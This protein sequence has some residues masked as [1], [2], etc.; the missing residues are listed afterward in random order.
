MKKILLL[1]LLGNFGFAQSILFK[2]LSTQASK[3]TQS[4]LK[5]FEMFQFDPAKLVATIDGIPGN[6][7]ELTIRTPEQAWTVELFEYD[8]LS[9]NYKRLA[10]GIT[11]ARELPK[12]SDFRTFKGNIKGKNSIVSL[13]VADGFMKLMI[14]DFSSR[15]FIEPLD[16]GSQSADVPGQHQY[17]FYKAS[18]IIPV[19]GVTCG[20]EQLNEGLKNGEQH[21]KKEDPSRNK[22]CVEVKIALV[23]DFTMFFKYK[24]LVDCENQMLSVMA[25][26]QTVF[27]NEFENEYVYEVTAT[28]IADDVTTDPFGAIFDIGTQL[29]TFRAI[30]LTLL[31][32][33]EHAVATC[34]SAKYMTGV[35]GIAFLPGVCSLDQ[36]NVCS[37]YIPAG[38]RQG[39]YLTLQAH[40]LG[41]NWSCI[42]D[43]GISPTIMAPVINGSATWSP[44]SIGFLNNHV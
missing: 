25:D 23:A 34:W 32:G 37:D 3:S 21:F 15:W 36:Y 10:G 40:E 16:S 14:D 18:D 29:N 31:N 17:L 30:A 27:D 28:K 42:H 41:H 26:V 2:P 20:A 8:L 7:K 4:H 19:E 12:R 35:I 13:S 6:V 24:T 38:G 11:D 1:L 22:R 5:S 39:N 44:L 33:V 9:P 43:A